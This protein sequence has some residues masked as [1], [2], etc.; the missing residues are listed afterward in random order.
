MDSVWVLVEYGDKVKLQYTILNASIDCRGNARRTCKR[1]NWRFKGSI[2]TAIASAKEDI[3]IPG[4][5]DGLM[6]RAA[7]PIAACTELNCVRLGRL[8]SVRSK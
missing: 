5:A 1:V 4:C 3:P 6:E 7:T 2:L 8:L